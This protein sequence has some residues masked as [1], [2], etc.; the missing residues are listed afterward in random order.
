MYLHDENDKD[1]PTYRRIKLYLT[2][3]LDMSEYNALYVIYTLGHAINN[4][5]RRQILNNV[6]YDH[7]NLPEH[8][9][10]IMNKFITAST[11]KHQYPNPIQIITPKFQSSKFN[12][13]IFNIQYANNIYNFRKYFI[14]ELLTKRKN[15]ILKKFKKK[16]KILKIKKKNVEHQ[17]KKKK[18]NI[19]E[20][21]EIK[22]SI[23]HL[24]HKQQTTYLAYCKWFKLADDVYNYK[25]E[26]YLY[27]TRII[28]SI[29]PTPVDNGLNPEGATGAIA[30]GAVT[31]PEGAV[32]PE[33]AQLS[34]KE[35]MEPQMEPQMEAQMEPPQLSSKKNNRKKN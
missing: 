23:D 24:T 28:T 35:Q 8:R 26:D 17:K 13:K 7:F 6:L 34:K 15:N 1:N 3:R 32:A 16:K 21:I 18:R 14:K 33:G 5:E 29:D 11:T 2:T 10:N 9:I 30:T 31:S 4:Y 27:P 22:N 25:L 20:K 19:I 12:K